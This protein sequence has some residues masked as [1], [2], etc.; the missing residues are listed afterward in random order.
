M[1]C[2][3]DSQRHKVNTSRQQSGYARILGIYTFGQSGW[4][5]IKLIPLY[6]MAVYP[7]INQK[8]G[9]TSTKCL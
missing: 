3:Y 2:K 4:V 8:T 6:T 9:I 5:N 7:K 1:Q